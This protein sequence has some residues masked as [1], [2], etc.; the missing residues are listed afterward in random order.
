MAFMGEHNI[1]V[2]DYIRVELQDAA[3]IILECYILSSSS[4]ALQLSKMVKFYWFLL[5]LIASF[6]SLILSSPTIVIMGD[7]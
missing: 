7:S 3:A 1:E 2:I 5:I 4:Y 6:P